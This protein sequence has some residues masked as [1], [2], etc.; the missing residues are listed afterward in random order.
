MTPPLDPP[1]DW[2]PRDGRWGS[3][4]RAEARVAERRRRIAAGDVGAA[5][6]QFDLPSVDP[7]DHARIWSDAEQA[8]AV[9]SREDPAGFALGQIDEMITFLGMVRLRAQRSL[10]LKHKARDRAVASQ[11]VAPDAGIDDPDFD[12]LCEL[13]ERLARLVEARA[14][15][16]R[17]LDLAARRS[18]SPSSSAG[19]PA[20]DAAAAQPKEKAPGR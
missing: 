4:T 5:L 3:P 6:E 16:A 14:T 19:P 17:R 10:Q 2:T 9:A 8:L 13:F 11:G 7:T 20:D 15:V 12:R 1:L 18:A